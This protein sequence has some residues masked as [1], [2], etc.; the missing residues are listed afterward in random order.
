MQDGSSIAKEVGAALTRGVQEA[1]PGLAEGH[2]VSCFASLASAL[3]TMLSSIQDDQ[4]GARMFRS[5]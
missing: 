3:A 5:L 4:V 1:A 2:S